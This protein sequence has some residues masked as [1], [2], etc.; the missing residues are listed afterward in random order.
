M[1]ENFF[2]GLVNVLALLIPVAS[3][4]SSVL[5]FCVERKKKLAADRSSAAIHMGTL[6]ELKLTDRNTLLLQRQLDLETRC[7]L[8]SQEIAENNEKLAMMNQNRKH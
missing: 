5:S 2:I 7:I 3:K 4:R 8:I 1:F 6:Q